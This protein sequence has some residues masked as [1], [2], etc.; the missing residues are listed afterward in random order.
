M[1]R[2]Q[3]KP[4]KSFDGGLKSEKRQTNGERAPEGQINL[5]SEICFSVKSDGLAE[6]DIGICRV[7]VEVRHRNSMCV[8][9]ACDNVEQLTAPLPGK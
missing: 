4:A 9:K 1:I 5:S 3:A 6:L 2:P 7:E 8:D